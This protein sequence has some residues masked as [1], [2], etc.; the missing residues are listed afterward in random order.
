MPASNQPIIDN[1]NCKLAAGG[2]TDQQASHLAGAA[3]A[4]CC[5]IYSVASC[6]CL[7]DASLNKGRFAYVQDL[8]DYR[9][10]NGKSWT[11]C[12]VSTALYNLNNWGDNGVW[13][14]GTGDTTCRSSPGSIISSAAT[15]NWISIAGRAD[16]QAAVKTDGTIWSW[17]GNARGQLGVGDSSNRSSPT[18]V[19]GSQNWCMVSMGICHGAGVKNDGTLWTWGYNIRGQLG[20]N[21]TTSRTSPGSIAGTLCGGTNWCFV[22]AT[23]LAGTIGIKTDG[24][25]W[26]WGYN[27]QGQLGDGTTTSRTSPVTTSGGGTNWLSASGGSQFSAAIKRDGTLWT[28]GANSA[29]QLGDGTTTSRSSPGTLAGGGTNWCAISAGCAHVAAIKTDG[30]LWTWGNNAAGKLGT[31]NTTSRSSPGTVAGGGTTWCAVSAGYGHTAAI[32]TDGTLWTWGCNMC[33]ALGDGT[34]TDRSSPGTIS[35]GGNAWYCVL[36][37]NRTTHALCYQ[38]KGF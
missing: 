4:L 19:S 31:G 17:G 5:S 9:Y 28:W 2:L 6:S 11:N 14:L 38:A 34:T 10:S 36:A 13:Q 30:T 29:G 8:C 35:G 20:D 21:S 3:Q 27:G 1:I 24:T 25:L 16:S 7:P 32:K 33:G 23:N 15:F 12:Y 37:A 26:T 22:S 18:T